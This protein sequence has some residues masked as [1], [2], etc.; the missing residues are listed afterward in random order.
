VKE[1]HYK[2][3]GWEEVQEQVRKYHPAF[4]E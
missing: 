2:K 4:Q 1:K 3:A